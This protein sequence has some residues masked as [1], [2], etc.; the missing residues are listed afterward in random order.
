VVSF[1]AVA[2]EFALI[3]SRARLS[4]T[5]KS[6]SAIAVS[7]EAY[8]VDIKKVVC[9]KREIIRKSEVKE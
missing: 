4:G 5:F 9:N 1:L 8:I 6:T 7:S 3:S 2:V